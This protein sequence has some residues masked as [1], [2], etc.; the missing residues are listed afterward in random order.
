MCEYV[1]SLDSD[2]W[3]WF[4][5]LNFSGWVLLRVLG[6][7]SPLVGQSRGELFMAVV[8]LLGFVVLY[9]TTKR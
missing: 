8:P 4:V 5:F 2:F 6:T 7:G 1:V 9:F 3:M